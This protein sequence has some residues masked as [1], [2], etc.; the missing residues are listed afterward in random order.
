M[1][2]TY[3]FF[4]I[5]VKS[6]YCKNEGNVTMFILIFSHYNLED[7]EIKFGSDENVGNVEAS[8][9]VQT[10]RKER[11]QSIIIEKFN[12]IDLP[13]FDYLQATNLNK[14]KDVYFSDIIIQLPNEQIQYS[15]VN[16][17]G[18]L[19]VDKSIKIQRSRLPSPLIF[20]PLYI[21]YNFNDLLLSLFATIILMAISFFILLLTIFILIP[22]VS[23]KFV[24]DK[25]KKHLK[26]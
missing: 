26:K 11:S 13:Q 20:Y 1:L 12:N 18:R 9:H 10:V 6:I 22:V 23:L 2:F 16:K 19:S 7:M 14:K 21:K 17:P 25:K 3:I 5:F 24:D 4:F 15:F 8:F